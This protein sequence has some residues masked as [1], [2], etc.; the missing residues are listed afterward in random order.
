MVCVLL[1]VLAALLLKFRV[2]GTSEIQT[3]NV[4]NLSEN[5]LQTI[6]AVTPKSEDNAYAWA[7][8][9]GYKTGSY[10]GMPSDTSDTGNPVGH[11]SQPSL[12]EQNRVA[13]PLGVGIFAISL[14]VL[15]SSTYGYY[16]THI[17]LAKGNAF[18][19]SWRY[20]ET[21]LGGG[22]TGSSD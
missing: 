18:A 10:E 8:L 22:A 14:F 12:L 21:Q 11:H 13:I 3:T 19:G 2:A 5:S 1:G 20:V 16:R 15:G 6:W 7:R 4:G 9:L 17:Q